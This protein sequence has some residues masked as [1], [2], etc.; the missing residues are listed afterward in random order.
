MS[1]DIQRLIA[2]EADRTNLSPKPLRV[3]PSMAPMSQTTHRVMK[4]YP[5]SGLVLPLDRERALRRGSMQTT[6][7]EEK[8]VELYL[9]DSLALDPNVYTGTTEL[10]GGVPPTSPQHSQHVSR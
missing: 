8:Y 3:A 2:T 9:R 10:R 7:G 4:G 1:Q 5:R 6:R